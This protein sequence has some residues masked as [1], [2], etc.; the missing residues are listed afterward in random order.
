MLRRLSF[1]VITLVV[2]ACSNKETRE[3]GSSKISE[4]LLSKDKK[5]P[6]TLAGTELFHEGKVEAPRFALSAYDV[7]VPLWSD[8]ARKQRFVFVPPGV[9]MGKDPTT[10]RVTFPVGTTFVKHF[11]TLTDPETPVE[12]RVISLKDD[13][14]WVY[15]TYVWNDDGTTTLNVRPR[16]IEKQGVEYRLPSE[17]ECHMCHTD[18]Q[19]IQGFVLEQLNFAGADGMAQLDKLH[20]KGIFSA[21]ADELKATVALPSPSDET[22]TVEQRTRVYMAVNCGSCHRPDGPEK[23]NV[24]DL[25]MEATDTKLLSEGKIVPGDAEA[26]IL[27]QKN[28]AEVERMP[29]MSLRADPLSVELFKR[30]LDEMPA[31]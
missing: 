3:E 30:W 11:T 4:A 2:P 22:L 25:R 12:T 27:Y 24:L 15:G 1:C 9:Q 14:K 18:G 20:A 17:E 13:G 16:K 10:G 19:P 28:I 29:N 21:T 7:K 26:S 31:Q 23:A 8:G 6:E 5:L